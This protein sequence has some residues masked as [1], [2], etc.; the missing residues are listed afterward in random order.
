MVAS[1]KSSFL[2][3]VTEASR[4][5]SHFHQVVSLA[6]EPLHYR[7]DFPRRFEVLQRV[8][9]AVVQHTGV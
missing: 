5:A 7:L 8:R 9:R 2:L 3:D 1:L 4:L 6:S